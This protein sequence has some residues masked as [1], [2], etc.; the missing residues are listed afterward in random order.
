M[1]IEY[2]DYRA[3]ML[4]EDLER[5]KR[6]LERLEA[7]QRERQRQF[8]DRRVVDERRVFVGMCLFLVSIG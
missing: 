5:Q 2:E 8:A 4:R 6:E 1:E 7:A 3:Q